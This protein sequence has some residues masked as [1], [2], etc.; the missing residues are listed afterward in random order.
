VPPQ[1]DQA[2]RLKPQ[3]DVL[4]AVRRQHAASSSP[5]PSIKAAECG[6]HGE[7]MHEP[8]MV[9]NLLFITSFPPSSQ[10][11]LRD[12]I[13]GPTGYRLFVCVPQQARPTLSAM[14]A[15]PMIGQDEGTQNMVKDAQQNF[16]DKSLDGGLH[17]QRPLQCALLLPV[18]VPNIPLLCRPIMQTPCSNRPIWALGAR[19]R[20]ARVS[21]CWQGPSCGPPQV[22]VDICMNLCVPG[23]H[24]L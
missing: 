15:D 7:A 1:Q 4:S 3:H 8:C 5:V 13:S 22:A 14:S 9:V 2:P 24:A 23:V 6:T 19:L 10:C 16:P 18:I 17:A 20:K 11:R 12:W 21:S